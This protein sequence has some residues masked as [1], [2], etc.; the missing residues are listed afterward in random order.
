M[1]DLEGLLEGVVEEPLVED[2]WLVLADWLEEHD[3]PQ[4]AELLRLHRQLLAT[5]CKPE[6]RYKRAKQHARIVELLAQG[7]KPCVPQRTLSLGDGVEM[8]VNFIPPG[9]F[10][11][12]CP[13]KEKGYYKEEQH[14]VTL[15]QGFWLAACLVTQAQWRAVLGDDSSNVKANDLPVDR[16]SWDDCMAFCARLGEMT[17]AR[18]RLPTEAQ[19]EYACRA[20]TT[21]PF[22]SGETISTEQAN[23]DGGVIYGQ[24]EK[25]VYRKQ[26]TPVSSFPP[27]AW[28]LF[29]MHGNL[30]EWCHDWWGDYST[31]DQQ[32]PEGSTSGETRVLRGGSWFLGPWFCRSA[33]RA[34]NAPD[35]RGHNFGCRLL[36]CNDTD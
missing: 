27:N 30:Y 24:G 35:N 34:T 18:F 20:G 33:Y 7:V 12:G 1:N 19:W 31:D 9:V 8:T 21:T 16:V 23:Y 29:D 6:R 13:Q 11:M 22:F 25:G 32:D 10:L 5:C 2:R 26:T 15:T 3:D 17:G 4:R 28:G 36:L 14:R